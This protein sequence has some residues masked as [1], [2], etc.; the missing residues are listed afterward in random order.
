M[1]MLLHRK[2]LEGETVPVTMQDDV[3]PY[4]TKENEPKEVEAVQEGQP[5]INAPRQ[6]QQVAT[7][8]RG[9]PARRANG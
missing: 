3:T 4:S 6:V 7:P 8:R 9:R 5:I 1:G 2:K